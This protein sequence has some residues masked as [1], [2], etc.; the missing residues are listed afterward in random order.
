MLFYGGLINNIMVLN[1]GWCYFF[2]VFYSGV[3]V[4]F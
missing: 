3:F 2:V 4:L 1:V